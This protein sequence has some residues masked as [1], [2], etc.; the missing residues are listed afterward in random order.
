MLKLLGISMTKIPFGCSAASFCP[1]VAQS[2]KTGQTPVIDFVTVVLPHPVSLGL[3][4][5][6]GLELASFSERV[7]EQIQRTD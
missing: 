3:R 1:V 7:N 4:S 6:F 2:V 5:V